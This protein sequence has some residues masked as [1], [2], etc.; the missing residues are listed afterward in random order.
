[1][2]L[3]AFSAFFCRRDNYDVFARCIPP[4]RKFIYI[5]LLSHHDLR[6]QKVVNTNVVSHLF[7]AR[8]IDC[9]FVFDAS[10]QIC[11]KS[12]AKTSTLD[13]SASTSV[14][15]NKLTRFPLE[16]ALGGVRMA[17]GLGQ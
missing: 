15:L 13:H 5:A 10:A 16:L 14:R 6:D 17:L 4:L 2:L 11:M 7:Q 8:P 1:M 9:A 3:P 12:S